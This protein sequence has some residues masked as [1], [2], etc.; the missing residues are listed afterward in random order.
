[1][2]KRHELP[3]D[4]LNPIILQ[5]QII[6]LSSELDKYRLTVRDYQ[7][8][9][10]YSQLEKLKIKNSHLLGERQQFTNQIEVMNHINL[11][12]QNKIIEKEA[13]IEGLR[14]QIENLK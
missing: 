3:D 11:T 14:K 5:Q 4:R 6:Y 2:K 10:H 1:M 9:Y 13:L 8:N 12:L 7:E